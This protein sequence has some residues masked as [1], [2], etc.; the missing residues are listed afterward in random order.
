M[1]VSVYIAKLSQPRKLRLSALNKMRLV[2]KIVYILY[3]PI[4]KENLY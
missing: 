4:Y 3:K 2:L 1:S